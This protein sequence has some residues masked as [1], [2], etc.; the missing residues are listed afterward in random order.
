MFCQRVVSSCYACT[1]KHGDQDKVSQMLE[2]TQFLAKGQVV[3]AS[4]PKL[5]TSERDSTLG[6]QKTFPSVGYLYDRVGRKC[7]SFARFK[8]QSHSYSRP[9]PQNEA[10]PCARAV[11][12]CG[13]YLPLAQTESPLGK[14]LRQR[15]V[16]STMGGHGEPAPTNE[17]IMKD[18]W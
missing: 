13:H 5:R 4:K 18:G 16:C 8:N 12:R 14:S 10:I 15:I 7:V 11:K 3:D 17:C 2:M 9:Y 1:H 6:G